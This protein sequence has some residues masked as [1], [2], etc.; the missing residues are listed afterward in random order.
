M[1][2]TEKRE[3]TATESLL[4]VAFGVEMVIVLFGTIAIAGA[5]KQQ[6]LEIVIAAILLMGVLALGAATLRRGLSP[7]AFV[8]QA[9]LLLPV[10]TE[11][12][13]LVAWVI[14]EIFW[15]SCLVK[16]RQLDRRKEQK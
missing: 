8:T 2:M 12:L 7:I 9:V 4:T 3:R 6:A 11:P 15:V 10:A 16:G 1:E 5:H 13:W 14:C